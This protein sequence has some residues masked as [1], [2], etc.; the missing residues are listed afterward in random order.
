MGTETVLILLPTE[1]NPDRKGKRRSIPMTK[2]QKTATEIDKKFGL[3]C[4][5]DL[6][7][8]HGFWA[9]SKVIYEDVNVLLE[10]D[11]FPKSER[12]RLI[13]YCESELLK[14]FKQKSIL[15][16]FIPD[17]QTKLVERVKK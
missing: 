8:K 10:I 4:T 17:V 12:K 9:K 13:K 5:L 6:Y 2:F 7:P 14:R 15:I 3:G 1:Y 11:S 16:K